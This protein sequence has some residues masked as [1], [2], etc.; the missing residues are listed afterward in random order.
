NKCRFLGLMQMSLL[1]TVTVLMSKKT[2]LT[3]NYMFWYKQSSSD[4]MQLVTYS[5]AQNISSIEAPFTSSKYFM[6]RP[7]VLT[8]SLQ[9][10][11]VEAGDAAVY[12]CASS[13]A[14]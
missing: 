1:R 13:K 6:S 10:R 5:A 4:K 7:E 8:S 3:H 12:Y 9:I 14:Q 2:D 11:Q